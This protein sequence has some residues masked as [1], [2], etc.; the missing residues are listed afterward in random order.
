MRR[1]GQGSASALSAAAPVT[2][3][4]V[5]SAVPASGCPAGALPAPLT[6]SAAGALP[7]PLTGSAAGALSSPPA[8]TAAGLL[9]IVFA[10]SGP[11]S[12]GA[13]RSFFARGSLFL[14]LLSSCIGPSLL[15]H[16]F[17]VLRPVQRKPADPS[18][19]A[20]VDQQGSRAVRIRLAPFIKRRL[21][22]AILS[23]MT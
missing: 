20:V 15:L 12:S 19:F 11:G 16:L 18:V 6:G 8:V 10:G 23:S 21:A 4:A 13:C 17:R 22:R 9:C 7:A 3:V 1:S 5:F 14:L 2:A